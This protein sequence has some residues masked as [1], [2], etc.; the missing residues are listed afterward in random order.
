MKFLKVKRV[1]LK[2]L[3]LLAIYA[4]C[5]SLWAQD[6][7]K[8]ATSI[9]G[10]VM[11]A[12]SGERLAGVILVL[13]DKTGK[14]VNYTTSRTDGAFTLRSSASAKTD[15]LCA[16]MMGYATLCAEPRPGEPM[17][18]KMQ[19]S[20]ISI[21][22]VT[23]R[24][25]KIQMK[26]DT[27]QYN[28]AS[29]AEA[30]D[31]NL[32]DVLKKLPGIDVDKAGQIKYNGK[33][34][35]KLYIE[36]M[37][38]L[39]GKYGLATNNIS[40][41]DV[42][43][44]EVL[45]NHQPTKALRDIAY[46]EQAAINV[47]LQEDAKA[48]WI[49]TADLG[50]GLG[51]TLFDGGSLFEKE[52]S[53]TLY[54]TS[55]DPVLWDANLFAMRIG[56]KWQNMNTFK[57]NNTGRDIQNELNTFT[58]S[59]MSS[60]TYQ[61]KD[62]LSVGVS[63]APLDEERVRM[64]RSFLFNTTNSFKMFEDYSLTAQASYFNEQLCSA[65]NN[66]TQY[67]LEDST[68]TVTEGEQ[69]QS[70]VSTLS[71]NVDLQANTDRFYL[72]NNL[73][74]S[75]SWNGADVNMTGSYPNTQSTSIHSLDI[76]DDFTYT[77]RIKNHSLSVS[78]MNQYIRMPQT[79]KVWREG[80]ES[81]YQQIEQ[82]AFHSSTAASYGISMGKGWSLTFKGGYSA[83]KRTLETELTG[84]ETDAIRNNQVELTHT[85][86][87]LQP[88][89]FFKTASFTASLNVPMNFLY[90][91][92]KDQKSAPVNHSDFL[93]IPRITLKYNVTSKF[94]LTMNGSLGKDEVDE[95]RFYSGVILGNYRSLN[96]GLINFDNNVAKSLSA[97]FEYRDPINNYFVNGTL[98][99][100]WNTLQNMSNQTFID[101]YIVNSYIP[102]RNE[103]S[104]WYAALGGSKGFYGINGLGGLDVSYT[105]SEATMKQG[106]GLAQEDTGV[107]GT[108]MTSSTPV[109]LTPYSYS[110]IS[111]APRF[112]ARLATWVLMDYKLAFNRR[113]LEMLT[114]GSTNSTNALRQSLSLTFTPAKPL[115]IKVSAEHYYNQITSTQHKNTVLA[116]LMVRYTMNS[117][118]ELTLTATN[119]LNQRSYSYT[120]YSGPSAYTA[121]YGIRPVNVLFGVYFKLS[122]LSKTNVGG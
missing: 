26:G 100:S 58:F 74:V 115:N 102:Y 70:H 25:P 43:S 94:F 23:V 109:G 41:T 121:S 17:E 91:H 78:S 24:A 104:I 16:S 92:I 54:A 82:S 57:T 46:S 120:S 105:N 99:R 31:R 38:L 3:F 79:L 116:D 87:Y 52:R 7:S 90:Y 65:N 22:E 56:A 21:R 107:D 42:K 110:L 45:E 86:L 71:A 85:K 101:S 37:D 97:G 72:K 4:T 36:G 14:M 28:V 59:D 95:K 113:T 103:S 51:G 61:L 117:N 29:F 50:A 1:V 15:T 76:S 93:T 35:N 66:Q 48:N 11:D 44:V 2:V 60:K 18:L 33:P 63:N 67:F 122:P 75:G 40:P 20:A 84:M 98:V 112:N 32:G 77:K 53:E 8:A 39:G 119:L 49:G 30:Q 55:G 80:G 108:A 13:K 68:L 118:V 69:A 5:G 83:L 111:I 114:S 27:I 12:Q 10:I 9:Y 106:L 19:T 73:S 6:A 96:Q 34:I 62:F 89:L 81:Q 88:T 64:N 47:K